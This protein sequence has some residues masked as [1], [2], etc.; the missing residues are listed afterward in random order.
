M[1]FRTRQRRFIALLALLGL[2]FQQV[3]MAAYVCPIEQSGT[4]VDVSN[5]P[6]CH[7]AGSDRIRCQT[8]CHPQPAS[9][10]QAPVLTVPAAI[11]PHTTW[12]RSAIWRPDLVGHELPCE[13]TVRAAAPPL[14]IQHCT[15]QI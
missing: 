8:H 6:S 3:A 2:L 10:D 15:Y 14:T 9:F 11:L 5:L 13:V 1:R 7:E 12:V 4:T